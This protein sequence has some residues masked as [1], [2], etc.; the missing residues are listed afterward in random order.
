MTGV[1]T[2]ALPISTDNYS[3][4]WYV[5]LLQ[6]S[7]FSD[8]LRCT[9]EDYRQNIL[10]TANIFAYIDS[11]EIVVQNAQ[12]RHFQKWPILGMSG[13]AP[14]FG[15][16][17]TTYPAELDSLKNWI[18]IRLQ[19]LDANIPGLCLI[20]G[21]T[22]TNLP[23]TLNCYPNPANDY[24]NVDYYLPSPMKMSV[25]L[26]NYLGSEVL[27]TTPITQT[28]GQHSLK[29]ETKTLSNGVYILKFFS[30]I[31]VLTKKIVINK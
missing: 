28:T 12:K 10:N 9:Y 29:L 6:D 16:V 19:W 8:E 26:Y 17:A 4:G 2:C 15:P 27:S 18:S 14:D 13:P 31:D 25:C 1:Q 5:R 7:T 24:F 23:A 30:G 22:E 3:T 20:T 21:V 11:M